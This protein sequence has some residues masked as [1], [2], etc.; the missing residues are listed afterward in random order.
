MEK[1]L[2]N[3]GVIDCGY[4]GEVVVFL[5][6]MNT[7]D[8]IEIKARGENSADNLPPRIDGTIEG[9]TEAPEHHAR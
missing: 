4:T 3:D 1:G 5:R 6:N 9:V 8:D 7:M 2:F